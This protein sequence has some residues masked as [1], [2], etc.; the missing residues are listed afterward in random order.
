MRQNNFNLDDTT[1]DT[2]SIN[3]QGSRHPNLYAHFSWEIDD[4]EVSIANQSRNN[5]TNSHAS[6]TS[7]IASFMNSSGRLR[8]GTNLTS[9]HSMSSI[10]T[11]N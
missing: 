4:E 9:K 7:S 3:G 8:S 5:S 11:F 10:G 1:S 6:M 2:S